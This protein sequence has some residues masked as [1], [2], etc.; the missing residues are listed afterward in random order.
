MTDKADE[1]D[2]FWTFSLRLYGLAGVAQTLLRLQEENGA[3]VNMMLYI[4]WRA[5]SG[6]RLDA[7]GLELVERRV[8]PWRDHVVRP[9]RKIRQEM[10]ALAAGAPLVEALR[11]SVKQDELEAERLQ[12]ADMEAHAADFPG[13]PAES[14]EAAARAGLSAYAALLRSELSA[15]QFATLAAAMVI[16]ARGSS[17]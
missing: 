4:L 7:A 10:K 3:D 11:Q 12:Q 2:A 17:A 15:P 1:A 8:A 5:A 14:V 6:Y 16:A 9:L 13:I